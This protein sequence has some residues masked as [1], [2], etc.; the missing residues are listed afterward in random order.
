MLV[1]SRKPDQAL[2][3][4]NDITVKVLGIEGDRVKLGIKAPQ[5]VTVLREEIFAQIKAA[6]AGAGQTSRN[7]LDDIAH[8]LHKR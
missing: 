5:T 7:S 2:L 6:N 1:L 4:G 8:A 3:L